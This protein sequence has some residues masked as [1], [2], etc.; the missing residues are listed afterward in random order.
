MTI[1]ALIRDQSDLKMLDCPAG[2]GVYSGL[3]I[4]SPTIDYKEIKQALLSDE[5]VTYISL[6]GKYK[7]GG[8][9]TFSSKDI[10]AYLNYVFAY[11]G[12]LIDE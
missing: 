8:Y 4:I 7:S 1:N 2:V 6:L 3:Y 5:F 9:Y 11:E 12:G 10:K